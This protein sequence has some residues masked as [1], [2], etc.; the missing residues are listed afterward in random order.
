VKTLIMLTL[1]LEARG[2]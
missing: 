2:Q 1:F